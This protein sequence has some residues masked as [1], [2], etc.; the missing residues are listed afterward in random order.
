M[1]PTAIAGT[2]HLTPAAFERFKRDHG[3]AL[4]SDVH[5]ILANYALQGDANAQPVADPDGYMHD[6]GN[7]LVV[8][9]DASAM[10]LF[11]F[12]MLNLRHPDDMAQVPSFKVLQ[13][14]ASYKDVD[15]VDHVVFSPSAPNFLS[16]GVW[17]AYQ[18]TVNRWE[19]IDEEQVPQAV[20]A[21]QND[22]INRHFF[23]P[24]ERYHA[25]KFTP[26]RFELI[27]PNAFL[28]DEWLE[29]VAA[30]K[31]PHLAFRK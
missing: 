26:Q 19:A 2:V 29:L 24:I 18:L 12:Y 15:E 23:D 28:A 5:F 10:R 22:L 11:Y 30:S 20:L 8:D 3:A 4:I 13:R 14:I 17:Q 25:L 31:P 16:D 9:Y 1:E 27:Y 6:A 7:R 21:Q